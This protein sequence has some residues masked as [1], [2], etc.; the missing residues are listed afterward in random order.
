MCLN[1]FS[2]PK[3]FKKLIESETFRKWL[4]NFECI[5]CNEPFNDERKMLTKIKRNYLKRHINNIWVVTIYQCT[6]GRK[7]QRDFKTKLS[8]EILFFSSFSESYSSRHHIVT[9]RD[10]ERIKWNIENSLNCTISVGDG[11]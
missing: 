9:F 7:E 2:K 8:N 4:L 10:E 6:Y 11:T 5:V 1:Y 3:F